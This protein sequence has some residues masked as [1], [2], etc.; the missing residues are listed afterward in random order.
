MYLNAKNSLHTK[1]ISSFKSV[2]IVFKKK[3]E[4]KIYIYGYA[5]TVKV[6][7][8]IFWARI[9]KLFSINDR[10]NTVC[11]N[12]KYD[13]DYYKC[14]YFSGTKFFNDFYIQSCICKEIKKN[15]S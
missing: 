12:T 6:S 9:M 14:V 7:C 11:K 5:T 3:S 8:T 4:A 13:L 10:K 2:F 15:S 1:Q